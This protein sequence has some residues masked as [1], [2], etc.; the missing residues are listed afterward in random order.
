MLNNNNLQ[1]FYKYSLSNINNMFITSNISKTLL[2][3]IIIIIE[4]I[5]Y[6]YIILN[7]LFS[8]NVIKLFIILLF[9][10]V[11][12]YFGIYNKIYLF[13]TLERK[14]SNISLNDYLLNSF[15]I[16][17]GNDKC[18]NNYKIIYTYL[19]ILYILIFK[20]IILLIIPFI[21]KKMK[22]NYSLSL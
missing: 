4:I 21:V 5:I 1:F 15:N 9:L 13:T 3:F 7:L 18:E 16:L 10:I 22:I 8:N 19:L 20:I 12:I 6:L 17:I 11:I 14:I 2:L